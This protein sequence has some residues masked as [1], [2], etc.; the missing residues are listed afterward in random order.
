MA[1]KNLR[2]Y[3][4]ILENEDFLTRISKQLSIEYE[5]PSVLKKYDGKKA[6]SIKAK[7]FKMDVVG[8]LCCNRDFIAKGLNI[9]KE[10]IHSRIAQATRSPIKPT[11]FKDGPAQDFLVD[12]VDLRKELPILKH[13]ERDGGPYI[14]SSIIIVKDPETKRV[15]ASYHRMMLVNAN[16]LL[17]RIVEGRD[18]HSFYL[19]SKKMGKPLEAAVVI[20]A[21]LELLIA[22]SMSYGS[23]SE[24]ELAGG[25]THSP[26]E[27]VKC[28]TVDLEV[29]RHAEI[30]L[31]GNILLEHKKEGPFVDIT[32]SYDVIRNQPIFQVNMLTRRKDAFYQAILSGGFEHQLLMGMPKEA[33]I[34][35]RVQDVSSVSGVALTSA[36]SNWLDVAIS[37]KKKHPNEPYLTAMAAIAAHYSLKRVII[38]DEDVD[39]TD[40]LMIEKAVLERAHPVEDYFVINNIMGSTL[41]KSVI[42]F[43][44]K[45]LPPAKIII[46]AT[47]KDKREFFEFGKI[48]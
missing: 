29:P 38:V 41:D 34:Y 18:L 32:G 30:I 12:N 42:R 23:I 22:A 21:P 10:K 35:D 46:D 6:V 15:N 44:G 13:Y 16:R 28:K 14:T 8:N 43:G 24:L 45:S 17:P 25:L 27:V 1:L 47:I 4:K 31:E 37:I 33:Q 36:G 20:G 9:P 7:G 26:L 48:L 5:I 11:I 3:I 40:L 2:E 19:K 39:V